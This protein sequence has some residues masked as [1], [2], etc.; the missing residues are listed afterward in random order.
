M[1]TAYIEG[2]VEGLDWRETVQFLID[3]VHTLVILG[4]KSDE[5]F[6]G[7]VTLEILGLV[8]NPFK[9]MLQPMKMLLV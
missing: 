3:R 9:R 5:A 1:G 4:E 8:I 7:V 6:L 2:I